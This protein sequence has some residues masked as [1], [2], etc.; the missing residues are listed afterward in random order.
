MVIL[1][2]FIKGFLLF[3]LLFS[4]TVFTASTFVYA[5]ETASGQPTEATDPS[6]CVSNELGKVPANCLFLEEPIGGKAGYDLFT[7]SCKTAEGQ[8]ICNYELWIGGA[9]GAN[10]RGPIQAILS[11]EAGKADQTP[12]YL[13]YNYIELVY[14]YLS[15]LIIGFVV[16]MVIAGGISISTSAGDQT[17]LDNGKKLIM[18][19]LIGMILWFLSSVI[20]YTINPTFFNF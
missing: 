19:S 20:L 4:F 12:F 2:K 16:L 13:L 1:N 10:T 15:G 17:Q 11:Y 7:V 3:F 9:V 18:K 5:E 14:K 8:T 6:D